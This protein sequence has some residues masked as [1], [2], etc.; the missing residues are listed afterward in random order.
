MIAFVYPAVTTGPVWTWWTVISVTVSRDSLG[1]TVKVWTY[2][3]N[4]LEI[5]FFFPQLRLSRIA[6]YF[7]AVQIQMTVLE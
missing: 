1:N 4:T 3:I 7:L 2:T 6:V 5:S